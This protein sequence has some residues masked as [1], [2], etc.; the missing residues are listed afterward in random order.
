MQAAP[1]SAST[2]TP[3]PVPPDSRS[4]TQD[5][6]FW[7]ATVIALAAA[8]FLLRGL[9]PRLGLRPRKPASTKTTLT[10]GGK[11]IPK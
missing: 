4:I 9:L 11:S 6:Q 2:K 3:N 8:A 5:P 1:T 7:I 10:V